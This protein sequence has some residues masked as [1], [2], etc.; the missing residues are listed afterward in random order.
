MPVQC[1]R[2]YKKE[3]FENSSEGRLHGG[4][5]TRPG[6]QGASEIYKYGNGG[7]GYIAFRGHTVN[8]DTEVTGA[9]M[10]QSLLKLGV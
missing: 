2:S 5:K 10:V 9:E 7:G 1:E 4:D 6:P 3:G 8:T